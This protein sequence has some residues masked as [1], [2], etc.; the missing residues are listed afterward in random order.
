MRSQPIITSS[1]KVSRVSLDTFTPSSARH[2]RT[3]DRGD[4]RLSMIHI[5][6]DDGGTPESPGIAGFTCDLLS[7]CVTGPSPN[8]PLPLGSLLHALVA[9]QRAETTVG[10]GREPSFPLVPRSFPLDSLARSGAGG[11]HGS[12]SCFIGE[13]CA[14]RANKR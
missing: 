2:C 7:A 5:F 10:R 8:L 11:D 13:D 1:K 12:L 14:R 6:C 9:A 4:F 3:E